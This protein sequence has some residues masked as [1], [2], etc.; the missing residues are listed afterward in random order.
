MTRTAAVLAV[1]ACLLLPGCDRLSHTTISQRS[2][3]DGVDTIHTVTEVVRDLATF[4]CVASR[5]GQ[6]RIVVYSRTC[7]AAVSLRAGTLDEHCAT[8]ALGRYDLRVGQAK[9]VRNLPRGFSHCSAADGVVVPDD[10]AV[11][12][13]APPARRGAR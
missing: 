1:S 10:C 11:P 12:A 13:G 2:T 7:E 8:R 4:R 9:S 3:A 6:C 5:T